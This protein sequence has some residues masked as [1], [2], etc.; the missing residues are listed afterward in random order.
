MLTL[1]KLWLVIVFLWPMVL[2][3]FLIIQK[4]LLS[5]SPEVIRGFMSQLG[6]TF[7]G[8]GGF[9]AIAGLTMN[10]PGFEI[11]VRLGSALIFIVFGFI[12]VLI[13]L[14]ED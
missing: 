2:K 5:K 6:W 7:V 3:L 1:F 10:S 13:N 14:A 8:A 11:K 12:L 4:L 9:G